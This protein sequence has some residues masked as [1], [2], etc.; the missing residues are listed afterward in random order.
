MAPASAIPEELIID[1]AG[2]DIGDSIRAADVTLPEG[3][4]LTAHHR[5]AT[6][7]SIA[8]SSSMAAEDEQGEGEGETEAA[9]VEPE[10]E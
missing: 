6:V 1:L 7:A 4:E 2:L 9:A 8:T 3:V 10:A 5:D